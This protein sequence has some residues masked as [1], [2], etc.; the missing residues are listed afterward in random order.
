MTERPFSSVNRRS[1]LKG[2]AAAG[3]LLGFGGPSLAGLQA[4]ASAAGI[5][6]HDWHTLPLNDGRTLP[7]GPTDLDGN[8]QLLRNPDGSFQVSRTFISEA[9]AATGRF[10]A[11][12]MHWVADVPSETTMA[13]EV[14]GWHAE[15]WSNW[16]KVGHELHPREA[17]P[18]ANGDETFTDVVELDHATR[19]QYRITLTTS[20]ARITPTVRRVTATQIDAL[21][22]PTL[23]D[24]DSRGKAIPFRVGNGGAPSTRLVLRQ[25]PA[26]WGPTEFAPG[27]P[28]Y[29]EPYAGQYPFQFVTIHHTAGAN[30]PENPVAAV[31]AVW[32]Y[33]AIVLG[34]GDVGYHF[35]VD[36]FGNV[37]QGRAGGDSTE[38]GH[39]FRYNHYN[40]GIVLLG[41]FQ[42]GATDVPYSGGDPS[43]AALDSAMRLAAMES[44]YHGLIP[45][46]QAAYPKPKDWCRPQLTNYRLCAH[47]DW[48][49]G[50]SCIATAC[51]GENLYQHM[52]AMREQAALLI[53]QIKDFSLMQLLNRR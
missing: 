48:G 29:W 26:G 31:R 4:S 22:S 49:R 32:Y 36:Q 33:H 42:P 9:Q 39:A 16:A 7:A 18:G 24:L 38:A 46:A 40:C 8:L 45:S 19:M 30:N 37:Y 28:L 41:Q 10:N 2:V 27:D 52:P 1:F 15:R 17:R 11:V 47:R 43:Q 12:G 13:V 44:A 3:T 34:W 51:P 5:R 20:D 50:G 53:P 21:D 35:L 6:A 23:V 14:R 25:G